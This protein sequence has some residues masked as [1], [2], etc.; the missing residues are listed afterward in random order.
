MQTK[1]EPIFT[2]IFREQS[3]TNAT[4]AA[5]QQSEPA[6]RASHSHSEGFLLGSC[7]LRTQE[8]GSPDFRSRPRPHLSS[9][10]YLVRSSQGSYHTISR[11]H[12]HLVRDLV[13]TTCEPIVFSSSMGWWQGTVATFLQS[14]L[15]CFLRASCLRLL[16]PSS[17]ELGVVVLV[18]EEY[19][20]SVVGSSYD[21]Y[22]HT[23]E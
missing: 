21:I 6:A 5:S 11:H 8:S 17:C 22:N 4:P 14:L 19:W 18:L 23:K 16:L 3:L 20:R 7:S 2:R 10:S 1:F 9:G 13:A 12:R 15:A